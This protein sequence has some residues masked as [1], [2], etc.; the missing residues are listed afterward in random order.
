MSMENIVNNIVTAVSSTLVSEAYSDSGTS[1]ISNIQNDGTSTITTTRISGGA[2]ATELAATATTTSA[3]YAWQATYSTLHFCSVTMPSF[4]YNFLSLTFTL[5]LPFKTLLAVGLGTMVATLYY[6]RFYWLSSYQKVPDPSIESERKPRLETGYDLHPDQFSAAEA[7]A[8]SQAGGFPN[9]VLSMFMKSIKIFGY[10]EEPVFHELS[11]QLQIRRLLAGEVMFESG[12]DQNFYVVIEGHVQVFLKPND[13]GISSNPDGGSH[14]FNRRNTATATTDFGDSCSG[15]A[16]GD[17]VVPPLSDIYGGGGSGSAQD[18]AASLENSNAHNFNSAAFGNSHPF[19]D[20]KRDYSQ[21][22]SSLWDRDVDSADFDDQFGD[23]VD[24]GDGNG[25]PFGDYVLLNDVHPGGVLSSLFSILSLFTNNVP[26]RPWTPRQNSY[27]N[28]RPSGSTTPGSVNQQPHSNDLHNTASPTGDQG[29]HQH[30]RLYSGSSGGTPLSRGNS[31]HQ[32]AHETSKRFSNVSASPAMAPSAPRPRLNTPHE[33]T[34]NTHDAP[35]GVNAG[36]YLGSG[37]QQQGGPFSPTDPQNPFSSYASYPPH[38]QR[39][40]SNATAYTSFGDSETFSSNYARGPYPNTIAR[41]TVDTTLAMIPASAFSRVTRLYPLAAAHMVQVI[42]TRLQRVTFVTL[43]HYLHMPTDLL[44]V[45]RSINHL[46]DCRLPHSL[47]DG[48]TLRRIKQVCLVAKDAVVPR[49]PTAN[50]FPQTLHTSPSMTSNRT[51]QSI[52][53][54]SSFVT[55]GDDSLINQ[56]KPDYNDSEDAMLLITHESLAEASIPPC[57]PTSGSNKGKQSHNIGDSYKHKHSAAGS[58]QMTPSTSGAS[59]PSPLRMTSTHKRSGSD[60]DLTSLIP[61]DSELETMRSEVFEYFC[62]C[63]GLLH[64]ELPTTRLQNQ[65]SKLKSPRARPRPQSTLGIP[66]GFQSIDNVVKNQQQR[67]D[68]GHYGY[69]GLNSESAWQAA[70]AGSHSHHH[71]AQGTSSSSIGGDEPLLSFLDNCKLETRPST[72]ASDETVNNQ[73]GA[74]MVQPSDMDMYFAPK[75]TVLIE[76]GQRTNG[77]YFV[78]DGLLEVMAEYT[79]PHKPEP[80]MA[81]G[82]GVDRGSEKSKLMAMARRMTKLAKGAS[83]ELKNYKPGKNNGESASQSNNGTLRSSAGGPPAASKRSKQSSRSSKP[84]D[85][86]GYLQSGG[87]ATT[88]QEKGKPSWKRL[89]VIN[90]GGLAGY[91]PAIS[92]MP[93]NLQ[94]SALT[95]CVVGFIPRATLD[96]ILDYYPIVLLSLAKRLSHSM[97]PLIMNVDYALEWMQVKSSQIIYNRGDPNDSVHVVLSGRLRAIH[98]HKNGSIELIDEFGQDQS[99]GE[100]GLLFELPRSFTLHAIRDTELVRIPKTLFHAL[101]SKY[102]ALTFHIARVIAAQSMPRHQSHMG[103]FAGMGI[104]LPPFYDED[105]EDS[106]D[107]TNLGQLAIGNSINPQAC[108]PGNNISSNSSVPASMSPTGYNY[109]LK[110]VGIIPVHSDVP[111]ANFAHRLQQSLLGLE[112]DAVILDSLTMSTVFGHRVFSKV[113]KL[114]IQTWLAELEKKHRLLLYVADGNVTSSWTR[115]CIHNVDCILLVGMGDGNTSIGEFERLVLSMK[116]TARKELV[117]LHP[118]RHCPPGT[119]RSW[120][121]HRIWVQ[122]YHHVQ[123]PLSSLPDNDSNAHMAYRFNHHSSR[124]RVLL[125]RITQDIRTKMHASLNA[126][127][128]PVMA[129]IRTV[130][131]LSLMRNKHYERDYATHAIPHDTVPTPSTYQGNRSDF[132]RLARRLCNRSVGVVMSGGGARGMALIGALRAFEEA[133]IPIDMVGG[134]SIGAFVSGLYARNADTVSIFGR[135]KSFAKDMSQL[136]RM[137]IDVTWPTL[138]YTSGNEFNRAIWKIFKDTLIEDLWLPFFC[139]TTN[140]TSSQAEVHTAGYLWKFVRA[141]MSLSS[142]VPPICDSRGHLLMDGGYVD[143]LPVGVMQKVMRPEIVF[144]LDI[145]GEDDTSPVHYGDA[146]S[147]IRVLLNHL[148]PFRK[149]WIPNLSDIQSRLAYCASVPQLEGAKNAQA[150]IYLKI[151]PADTG[152]LD[153]GK[154][155]MLYEKGYIYGKAWVEEW[156]KDGLMDEWLGTKP[157]SQLK[158]R[159]R[160]KRHIRYNSI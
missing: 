155:D 126:L 152:V 118:E 109:N 56:S 13:S 111:V 49:Q 68:S 72:P 93:S 6:V 14:S 50:P 100:S 41:A 127:L 40:S 22:H 48:Q 132:A 77:L 141:S 97:T 65:P 76:G 27:N 160:R 25:D 113:G 21:K 137:A 122:A 52:R 12:H 116:T 129:P 94:I 33:G 10:L 133:G 139:M 64:P 37:K 23:T 153:F 80:Y 51:G 2:W 131:A 38:H 86:Q 103:S 58:L 5:T 89:Y 73:S 42:L 107:T 121:K 151:P 75:G 90:P 106:D 66:L 36:A 98:Q 70:N 147:G 144:A 157:V 63:I 138:A 158:V 156:K 136:W 150:C 79:D 62:Q 96:K 117:L 120:L 154:F 83:E 140:I 143:N 8:I 134:T 67:H 55:S 15:A 4:I 29:L 146:V 7:D 20:D 24:G 16:A 119:T 74:F 9:K 112:Q 35:G 84:G 91:L 69:L 19:A 105:E 59:R 57:T 31:G 60:V 32:Y 53:S 34:C 17:T 99:V 39:L 43:Q 61:D 135:A 11:R 104:E 87:A 95:D 142:F 92:D 124:S 85:V 102:P 114:R 115:H 45:E 18:A 30:S 149:Y 159:D 3:Y 125:Q 101:A 108:M 88:T 123:M 78:V 46:A 128:P 54:S 71:Q 110:T 145:A 82:L 26:L 81:A 1:I 47:V 44:K 28:N 130:H 148:N